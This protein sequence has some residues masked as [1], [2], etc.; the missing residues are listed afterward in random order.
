MKKMLYICHVD[1]N[2]I[3]QRPHF[4]AEGLKQHFDLSVVYMRQNRNR[5]TLQKRK[6]DEIKATP[7][8]II[9]FFGRVSILR[10]I[11]TFFMAKQFFKKYNEVKPEYIFLTYP[12]QVKLIPKKYSGKIIYDCM[13]D[14]VAMA[15]KERKSFVETCERDLIEKADYVF[16][17]SQN[18]TD[19]LIERYS[20][21]KK[22]KL[23][24]VRNGY[25]GKIIS[26]D[27]EKQEKPKNFEI[28]YI[29]TVSHWFNFDYL[30]KSLVDFENLSYKI[31]GPIEA[32]LNVPQSQR[33][34]FVGTVE[35]NKL[36]E[37][38]KDTNCLIMPFVVN[39]I[40][41]SVDPVKL[42]EYINY[43]KDIICVKYKEIL[44]FDKF[45]YFYDDYESFKEQLTKLISSDAVKYSLDE[46]KEFLEKNNWKTRVDEIVEKI[47]KN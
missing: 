23:S 30:L 8:Y 34:N 37:T 38:I 41:E 25:D 6:Q 22:S 1:W 16:V 18:L 33:I 5:K 12:D 3:K 42:Y 27:P 19:K 36:Y 39:E 13:D 26:V 7:I 11:N 31:I 21:T 2:W 14:H 28:S 4:L 10:R 43:N 40:I 29:G 24:V 44:R 17:S 32:G 46:R 45:V 9:P 47:S 35:H 15:L 20:I